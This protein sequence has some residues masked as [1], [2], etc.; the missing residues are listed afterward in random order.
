MVLQWSSGEAGLV[1]IWR[2][3]GGHVRKPNGIPIAHA[4]IEEQL[5]NQFGLRAADSRWCECTCTTSGTDVGLKASSY[6]YDAVRCLKT[7]GA[8]GIRLYFA[9]KL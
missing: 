9:R 7:Q 8:G 6:C 2:A 5:R 3:C 1:K 4:R